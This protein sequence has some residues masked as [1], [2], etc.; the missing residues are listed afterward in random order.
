M[1]TI[2]NAVAR[3]AASIAGDRLSIF[4]WGA[5]GDGVADDAGAFANAIADAVALG[6]LDIYLPGGYTYLV[7]SPI[8]IPYN[9]VGLRISGDGE[10]S[11]IKRG[12]NMS[13]GKGVIDVAAG[14]SAI[15]IRDVQLDGAVTS[16]DGLQYGAGTSTTLF[17][18]DPMDSKLVL[19]SSIWIHGGASRVKVSGVTIRHTGGY[20]MLLDATSGD[21]SDVRVLDCTLENCRP[22]LFG[23]SGDLNYGSWTGGI[24]YQGDGT[25]Y[26]VRNLLVQGC[27]F[28]RVLGN[29]V[30]GHLY[31]FTTL[32]SNIRVVQN[33]FD[34]MGLDAILTGGVS[35]S[36]V[37]GNTMSRV[38]YV[39][40]DDASAAVPKWCANAY[41]VGIDTSG[42]G[43]NVTVQG[44]S[45]MS[46]NGGYIDADGFGPGAIE[47][48]SCIMPQSG[49]PEYSRDSIAISGPANNG[50]TASYGVQLGNTSNTQYGGFDVTIANNEFV[51]M[52]RGAICGFAA[53]RCHIEGNNIDHPSS[54][55][56][57]PISL[58]N[59]G[60]GTYQRAYDNVVT[61]N[62]ITYAPAAQAPAIF[63]DSTYGAF[64]GTDKNWVVGNHVI[65]A[66]AFEFQKDANSSSSTR[67]TLPTASRVTAQSENW[68]QREGASA[69]ATY[70]RI[71]ASNSGSQ[72]SLATL[73]DN[74]TINGS[75]SGTGPL[76]CVTAGGGTGGVFST[77]GRTTSAVDDAVVTGKLY[78]DSFLALAATTYLATEANRFPSSTALLRYDGSTLYVSTSVSGG[79]R[80]WLALGTAVAAGASGQVQ[81]NA[82]GA[83]AGYSGLTWD[84]AASR[85]SISGVT[86][87]AA[88]DV[89]TG[90]VQSA[91]GFYTTSAASSA[92]NAPS[93]GVTALSLISVRNDATAGLTLSRTSGIARQY[94]L[95]INSSGA[96]FLNDATAGLDRMWVTSAGLFAFGN[97]SSTPNLSIDQSGNLSCIGVLTASGA[98]AGVNVT[99]STAYNSIQTSGGIYSQKSIA[100]DQAIYPKSQGTTAPV[101][102]P[103]SG[104][105]GIS[106]RSGSTYWYYNGSAWSYVDFSAGGGTPAGSST[107]VQFNNS[108][109]FGADSR[110]AWDSANAQ[111]IIGGQAYRYPHALKILP[112]SDVASGSKRACAIFGSGSGD[113]WELGQDS[114]CNGGKDF[115]WYSYPQNAIVWSIS[116]SKPNFGFNSSPSVT[117]GVIITVGGTSGVAGVVVSG[118]YVQSAEGYYSTG[119]SYQ[120]LNVPSGGSYARSHHSIYYTD[121][122]QNYG[123]PSATTGASMR[124]GCMYYDTA[125]GA[126]KVHNGSS[127][128]AFGSSGVSSLAASS[129]V[130]VSASTGAVTISIASSPSFTGTVSSTTGFDCGSSGVKCGGINPFLGGSQYYGQSYDLYFSGGF[131]IG[132]STFHT[133][134]FKGGVF[135]SA[136]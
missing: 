111:L 23:P 129:P 100:L 25:G 98:S 53:R 136:S 36:A 20:A 60:T 125:A 28:R 35:D 29:G 8:A 62:R 131:T 97:S 58:G 107:Q 133:I 115:Y 39:T 37:I 113:G 80:V 5:V 124:A 65:G 72:T 77:G 11:L 16:P 12:A 117:S 120:T 126:V 78:A 118:G 2:P 24:H 122:G 54:P 61:K 40:I 114:G 34:D 102:A 79:A 57:P 89:S 9:A 22:H 106:H 135:V 69:G 82:S 15:E 103:G 92:I 43:R 71:Y 21:I 99:V 52:S 132:G 64:S 10:S 4:T 90:Y 73:F 66:N 112:S 48:N 7:K 95:G 94:G 55:L 108:G 105:G 81:V 19:N 130:Q 41:A 67:L 101:F 59:V 30:W 91:G 123:D 109:S 44:N 32:H 51:N 93:G 56:Y 14:A 33:H 121:I 76:L 31:G 1:R 6:G 49:D 50:V 104:Y 134:T 3:T 70:L 38:G 47:G 18:N 127:F 85:L 86:G 128:V 116:E 17:N 26:S 68:L 27:T 13:A 110:F 42:I 74:G 88:L 63:E 83:L 96:L 87:T 46:V 75:A 119:T 45:L 84:S